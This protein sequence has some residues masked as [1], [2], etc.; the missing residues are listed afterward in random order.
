MSLNDFI[1]LMLQLFNGELPYRV[2]F[3]LCDEDGEEYIVINDIADLGKM[4][5]NNISTHRIPEYV[6]QILSITTR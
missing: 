5:E 1:K 3:N 4:L 2:E 6:V